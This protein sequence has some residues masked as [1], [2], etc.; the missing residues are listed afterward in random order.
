MSDL[1]INFIA[2]F[3]ELD[4]L[5]LFVPFFIL[6]LCGLGLPLPEDIILIFSGFLVY[7]GYGNLLFAI[8]LGYGGII[9]GDT[10]IF[11]AGKR[12]GLKILKYK[13][14]S[15]IITKGRLKKAKRF[16]VDH[17]RKTIFLARFLPGL[18]T[19]IFFSCGTLKVKFSQ[20]FLI[21]SLAA[22]VSAPLFTLLG[23]FFGD[24]ID[25]LI[26]HLKKIDRIVLL[27]LIAIFLGTYLL[28]NF[29][30]KKKKVYDENDN[31]LES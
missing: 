8:L 20:F 29:Y 4:W 1:F 9:L 26:K 6:I 7:S 18:R 30:N 3:S 19:P 17:G 16:I 22:I 23:Y 31:N 15:K 27:S 2:A 12:Y 21:D 25:I 14:F 28:K 5:I 10:I 24:K 11:L 13:P